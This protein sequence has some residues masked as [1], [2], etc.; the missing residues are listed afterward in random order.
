MEILTTTSGAYL[1]EPDKWDDAIPWFEKAIVAK[2][3]EARCYPQFNLGRVY[4]HNHN[5]QKAQACYAAA[6]ALD[7]GYV[8]A[9]A[10]LRRLSAA[11]N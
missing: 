5:W 11:W 1:I 2:R 10:G 9:L 4:E 3:Y 7:K 6:Y 8:A